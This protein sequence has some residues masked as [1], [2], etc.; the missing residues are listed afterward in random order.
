M[1][2]SI[3]NLKGGVGKTTTAIALACM[4]AA[5]GERVVVLDADPQGSATEWALTAEDSGTPL[6][7]DVRPANV[8]A[9][10]RLRQ[11]DAWTFID[12]PPSGTVTDEAVDK[13]DFVVVPS[14]PSP[15]D[16]AKTLD[17]VEALDSKD[18]LYGILLTRVQVNTKAFRT[19]Q[20]LLEEAEA[21]V[22]DAWIPKREAIANAFG[23]ALGQEAFGYEMV[24]DEIREAMR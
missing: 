1:I 8:A 20:H 9:I 7:F 21:S 23:S 10:R 22:F 6:P 5:R 19:T 17:V 24:Y 4:A 18:V 12:C 3:T 13:A 11:S 16:L 14:S 2:V 15:A